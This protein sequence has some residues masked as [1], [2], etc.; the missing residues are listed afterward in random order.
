MKHQTLKPGLLPG[1]GLVEQVSP[2]L[3]QTLELGPDLLSVQSVRCG[4]DPLALSTDHLHRRPA[5]I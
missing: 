4:C 1:A 2:S 5:V 3:C